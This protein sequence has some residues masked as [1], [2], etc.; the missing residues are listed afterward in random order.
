[1][2]NVLTTAVSILVLLVAYSQWR[3]A[4]Q[5]VVLDLFD[6]RLKVFNE[7][8]A[9]IVNICQQGAAT[10]EDYRAF[11]RAMAEARFLFGKPV[12]AYLKTVL[13]DVVFMRVYTLEVIRTSNNAAELHGNRTKAMLRIGSYLSQSPE[14]FGPYMRL[15]QKNTPFWRPW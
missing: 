1:M 15:D 10:E 12:D 14:G 6:R 7:I 3:T 4:N 11:V 2:I 8:E 13:D 9:I 5:R